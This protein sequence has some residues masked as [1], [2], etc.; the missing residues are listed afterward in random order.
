[1]TEFF[2]FATSTPATFFGTLFL[3]LVILGIPFG[4]ISSISSGWAEAFS[5]KWR[6]KCD[7]DLPDQG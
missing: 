6:K 5:Y 3:L 4:T 1:M 7:M 2:R